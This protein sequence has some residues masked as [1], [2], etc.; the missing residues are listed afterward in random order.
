MDSGGSKTQKQTT[1]A[2][3]YKPSQPGLNQSI[4]DVTK[5]YNSG[6]LQVDYPT[7]TVAGVAPEQGLAW[8]G[9]ADRA[10]AG[11]PLL[12][13]AQGHASDLIG[14]KYLGAD[15]PGL[16]GTL[17]RIASGVKANYSMNGRYGSEAHDDATVSALSPFLFDNYQRERGAQDAAMG[18]APG[19]AREDYYDLD[20]LGQVG[21]ERRG[22][23][24]EFTDD[25]VARQQWDQQKMANAIALYQS[26]LGGNFGGSTTAR[27]PVP[28]TSAGTQIAGIGSSLLG[29]YLGAGG[30][31]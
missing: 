29:S 7:T 8:K 30:F 9:I 4:A 25:E 3:P 20:R 21:T 16:Q 1:T 19:L 17:D 15:A 24:Q 27:V 5:L 13:Q 18:A 23:A 10:Q 31:Q 22:V 26:L 14:G 12:A 2:E 11:N 6:G 28:R